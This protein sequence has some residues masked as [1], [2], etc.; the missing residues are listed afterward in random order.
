[1]PLKGFWAG[2]AAYS[3]LGLTLALLVLAGF[4]GGYWLDGKIG[5]RPLLAILGAFLGATAGFINLVRVLN[6]LQKE[7]ERE[8][9][10]DRSV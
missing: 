3:H 4:F 2:A 5:T 8:A 10:E 1:M 7:D 6:Q 9:D